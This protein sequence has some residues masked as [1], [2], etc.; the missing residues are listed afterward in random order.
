MNSPIIPDT[1]RA[2]AFSQMVAAIVNNPLFGA[3]IIHYQSVWVEATNFNR[4]GQPNYLAWNPGIHETGIV[5]ELNPA[6]PLRGIFCQNKRRPSQDKNGIYYGGEFELY[7]TVDLGE[8]YVL[9]GKFPRKQDKFE[10]AGRTYYATSPVMPCQ[11]GD[12]IAAYKID[13]AIERY[14]VAN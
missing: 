2:I 9:D 11:L 4:E 3:T 10:I 12:T 7:L 13:L 1:S 6:N 8:V 5:Y 14:P